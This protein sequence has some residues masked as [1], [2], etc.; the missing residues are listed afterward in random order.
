MVGFIRVKY[1]HP[2]LNGNLYVGG[3]GDDPRTVTDL[4]MSRFSA[5]I[6]REQDWWKYLHDPIV[7]ARWTTEGRGHTWTIPAPS[8]E[9][10]VWL[11]DSQ[12]EYV[13]G[14][15]SGYAQLRDVQHD[16]QVSCYD[17]IWESD[18]LLTNPAVANF[19]SDIAALSDNLPI[20]EDEE[21]EHTR[22]IL[23]PSLYC[24]I[25]GRTLAYDPSDPHS[26]RPEPPPRAYGPGNPGAVY[27]HRSYLPTDFAVSPSGTAKAISYINNLHPRYQTLYRRFEDILSKCIPL[28]EHVLTDLHRKNVTEPRIKCPTSWPFFEEPETP[29]FETDD[30]AWATYEAKKRRWIMSRPVMVPDVLPSGYLGGLEAR[31]H[32]VRLRDRN[33]QVIFHVFET[34]LLPGGQPY[35]GSIWLVQGIRDERIVAC[36]YYYASVENITGNALE[37]RTAVK[38]P[39]PFVPGD[40]EAMLQL[41][42][43]GEHDPCH[44]HLGSVPIRESL[45]VAFPNIYQH[46]HSGFSLLDPSRPGHQRIVGVFLVEPNIRPIPS[47]ARV[48]PQQKGWVR[49]GIEESKFFAVELVDKIMD[50]TEGLMDEHEAELIRKDMLIERDQLQTKNNQQYFG[51]RLV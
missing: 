39:Q 10:E 5:F 35:E 36:A 17:R 13:L 1:R 44:Q 2:F 21:Y 8:A 38:A 46:R 32:I 29:E 28:Y 16:C 45:C 37:F 20:P 42:G 15:L 40:R 9:I 50:E 41:W 14:E 47:T 34:R 22:S 19:R 26:L 27:K 12:V 51:V 24:L 33:L 18:S 31:R 23:D 48:P 25:Y 3:V 7:R 4:A 43:L 11:S 6:R 49:R 30:I